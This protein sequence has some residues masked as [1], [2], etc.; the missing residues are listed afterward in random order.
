MNPGKLVDL[1]TGAISVRYKDLKEDMK[2]M[3]IAGF[4]NW[5]MEYC[6]GKFCFIKYISSAV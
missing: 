1:V 2:P 4:T 3:E 5:P 6:D